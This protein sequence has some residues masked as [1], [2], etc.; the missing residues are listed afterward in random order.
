MFAENR[1]V[2]IVKLNGKSIIDIMKKIYLL[3]EHY[4]SNVQ[5]T[6]KVLFVEILNV[7]DA[8]KKEIIIRL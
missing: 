8:Y 4:V 7:K 5:G 1:E 6:R 3:K 2:M